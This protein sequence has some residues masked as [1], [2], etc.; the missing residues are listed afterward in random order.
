MPAVERRSSGFAL[1]W[2]A[3]SVALVAIAGLIVRGHGYVESSKSV[4]AAPPDAAGKFAALPLYFELNQGQSDPQVHYLS[5]QGNYSVYL[6]DDAAVFSIVGGQHAHPLLP[7][8]SPHA[9]KLVSSA[10]RVRLEGAASHPRIEGRDRLRGRVNYLIGDNPSRWR[11]DIPI[12]GSVVYHDVYPGVDLVYYGAANTLEYDLEVRP[13]ADPS[14]IKFAIEGPGKATLDDSGNIDVATAAGTISIRKPVVYQLDA[15][16]ARH[17]ITGNFMLDA[18]VAK[19]DSVPSRSVTLALGG[20]DK[21]RTVVIDPQFVYSSLLGGSGTSLGALPPF[22]GGSNGEFL[23]VSD[24]SFADAIDSAG[25]AYLTGTTFSTDFPTK[26]ALQATL[27]GVNPPPTQNPNAFVAKFDPTMSG[28]NSLIYSTYLGGKGDTTI[29]DAGAGNGDFATGIAVD[30]S[31]NV[32]LSGYTFSTDFPGGTSCGTWGNKN[33]QV[34]TRFDNGFISVLNSTGTAVDYSCYINSQHGAAAT[35]VAINPT[36]TNAS[37]CD[38]YAS[39]ITAATNTGGPMSDFPSTTNAFFTSSPEKTG[40]STGF[41]LVATAGGGGT[42]PKYASFYGGTGNNVGG[43]A[44]TAIAVDSAGHG[45]MTGFSFS[46]DLPHSAK[47]GQS[48][49]NAANPS[50]A[51]GTTNAFICEFDPTMIGGASLIYSSYYGGKGIGN[52]MANPPTVVQGDVGTGIA[53]DGGGHIFIAGSAFSTTG[54]F[55]S[56]NAFQ[57]VN[58]A[59]ANLG[60]NAFVAEIDTTQGPGTAGFVYST[61]FGGSGLSEGPTFGVGDFATSIALNGGNVYIGG[62]SSSPNLPTSANACQKAR[63][64]LVLSNAFAA[65]LNPASSGAGQLVFSSY[66]GG[67]NFQTF[68]DIAEDL[69]VDSVNGDI[70]LSG[71]TQTSNFPV[72][73]SAFQKQNKAFNATP[74]LTNAFLTVLDPTSNVCPPPTPSPT[75]SPSATPTNTATPSVTP[76]PSITPTVTA[77]ATSTPLPGTVGFAAPGVIA[78]VAPGATVT[79]T[80]TATNSTGQSETINTITIALSN[81]QVF[82]SLSLAA[83]DQSA[84]TVTVP[85]ATNIFTFTPA[86]TLADKQ[87]QDFTVTAVV[88][89]GSAMISPHGGIVYASITPVNHRTSGRGLIPL[90]ASL[91]M[92]GF[93][94]TI[95]PTDRRKRLAGAV[96]IVL[97]FASG[98]AGCGGGGGGS[99]GGGGGKPVFSLINVFDADITPNPGAL[100]DLPL[101]IAQITEKK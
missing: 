27:A 49:N 18:H 62:S 61:Y 10:M 68:G 15:S 3:I 46:T 29:G 6:T 91:M 97:V 36:C 16:G 53:V 11:R 64:P 74:S 14:R 2:I 86:L 47:A 88:A 51:N 99:S 92:I 43:D 44:A 13:G 80:F 89:G 28:A 93:G 94:L 60:S 67:N 42:S 25:D 19:I 37:N 52:P 77:T 40:Q 87:V 98:V 63:Y 7:G 35:R 50:T 41:I 20:Y 72:T 59:A 76:T 54:L 12:F 101:Q 23:T 55:T 38:V 45:Y 95:F 48:V 75:P 82:S 5:R 78:T 8:T 83:G 85:A 57:S 24:A 79:A 39:G 73:A 65:E 66:F 69:K 22:F 34:L 4:P 9:V 26:A 32:Y 21:T 17:E 100:S 96:L 1:A 33:N 30:A 71:I 84:G 90:L 81:P 70:Y 31:N 56:A 58:N